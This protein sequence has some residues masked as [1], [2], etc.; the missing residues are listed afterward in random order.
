MD[1]LIH[2]IVNNDYNTVNRLLDEG[3]D[4]NRSRVYYTGPPDRIPSERMMDFH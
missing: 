2:A 4:P 1:E 3:T